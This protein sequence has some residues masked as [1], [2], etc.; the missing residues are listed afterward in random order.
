MFRIQD[1]VDMGIGSGESR[2]APRPEASGDGFS[3][4]GFKKTGAN[5]A[6]GAGAPSKYSNT[7]SGLESVSFDSSL[8]SSG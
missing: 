5:K 2:K 8:G 4:G 1:D 6:D 3:S 7:A